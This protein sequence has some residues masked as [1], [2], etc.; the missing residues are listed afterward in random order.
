M[1][2]L[3]SLLLAIPA[4]DQKL[5]LEEAVQRAL[6][7]SPNVEVAQQEI[8]R[9]EG[10]LREVR[11]GS[12][13]TLYGNGVYT[14][15]DAD[16]VSSTGAVLI[17]KNQLQGNLAL[18]LPLLAPQRW[19]Q[20]A[21]AGENVE[22]A[23]FSAEE[24]RRSVAVATARAYLAVFTQHRLV[25][26]NELSVANA[27]DHLEFARARFEAGSG[28]RLDVVRAGQE[29]ATAASQVS[30]AQLGLSRA[31]EALGVL[32]ADEGPIDT[33]E[34]VPLP[35]PP[36]PEAALQEAQAQRR[37]VKAA[38]RRLTAARNVLH[39]SYADYLP[40]LT[41]NVSPF[42]QSTATLTSPTS[43]WQASL[44][45]S[46]PFYDGGLRYGQQQERSALAAEARSQL[47]GLLRQAR[48]EVR[49]AFEAVQRAD[50][51]VVSAQEASRLSRE[52]M[53][54][55]QLAYKE[56]ATNDL[57]VVDAERRAR[58]ADSQA[59]VSE[60]AARQARIDLLTASGRFP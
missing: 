2:L 51:A 41:A 32:V 56:G 13:P 15:L 29:T 30:N 16:R 4:A 26:I 10:L 37:D 58:D 47:D 11:S 9:A 54:I 27:R 22:V 34:Q 59:L 42:V 40:L 7:R 14:R 1:A 23:R 19:V 38:A 52:A 53:E 60:D 50:E 24:V 12:F 55:T 35:A 45:L 8:Q 21:H 5:S 43:G 46:I 33:L 36:T 6:Q 49:I 20:W 18:S 44:V 39:D 57:D 31:K 3:L 25:A 17:P 48:S 28:N